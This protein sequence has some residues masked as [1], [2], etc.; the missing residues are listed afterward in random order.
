MNFPMEMSRDGQLALSAATHDVSTR[1]GT[2]RAD[3]GRKNRESLYFGRLSRASVSRRGSR[4][5][6]RIA[7]VA[8]DKSAPPI[9]RNVCEILSRA[10]CEFTSRRYVC[11]FFCFFLLFFFFFSSAPHVTLR[12]QACEPNRARTLFFCFFSFQNY[13]DA[14]AISREYSEGT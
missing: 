7:R 10:I 13:T 5:E 8:A 9:E 4:R 11:V 6:W 14:R 3:T 1:G 2:E 12:V